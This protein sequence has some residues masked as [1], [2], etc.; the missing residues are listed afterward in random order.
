VIEPAPGAIELE[1]V[2]KTYGGRPVLEGV[3]LGV[4][5]GEIVAL[6]GPNGA[7]KTT[8]VEIVEGYRQADRGAVRVLGRDPA[9]ADRAHRARIGLMLQEGGVDPR[10][11]AREVVGLHGAFHADAIPTEEILT[12]VGLTP[13][14]SRT[15]YRRLSGGERQRVALAVALVGR[16][17][18]AVLDEPTAGMDVEARRA[19]RELLRGLRDAGVAI[20]LTSH[21]LADVERVANRI[22]IL[23]RGRIVAAESIGDLADAGAPGGPRTPTVRLR[24]DTVL[25]E[26]DR[27]ELSAVLGAATDSGLEPDGGIGRYR[28]VGIDPDPT[29]IAALAAWCAAHAVRILELRTGASSLEERYLEL[30]GGESPSVNRETT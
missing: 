3:S 26:P 18:V 11:T 27:L 10:M 24:L 21:D 8:T 15:R 1:N 9:R 12:R 13:A 16:P 29:A 14:T 23:D 19:V 20:L 22:A 5:A 7:G 30:T 4:G 28:A 17:E 2:H 6:L 25:S